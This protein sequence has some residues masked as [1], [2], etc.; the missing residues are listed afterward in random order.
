[1]Y[2]YVI[3]FFRFVEGLRTLGLLDEMQK[4]SELFYDLF[5]CEERPLLARDLCTLFEVC[6]ST[7]GS[8]KRATEN[9]TICYWRDWLID[10]EGK[11]YCD[12]SSYNSFQ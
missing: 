5:V 1:M 6:F 8:N 4:N 12:S 10:I 11:F 7:Q 9:Q 3:L 2:K